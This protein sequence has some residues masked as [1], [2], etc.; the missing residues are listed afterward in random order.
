MASSAT[1][2]VDALSKLIS[3][4]TSNS[5][6]SLPLLS[7]PIVELLIDPYGSGAGVCLLCS[8]TACTLVASSFLR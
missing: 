5:N 4:L 7:L 2:N 6:C 8:F 1:Q 3:G